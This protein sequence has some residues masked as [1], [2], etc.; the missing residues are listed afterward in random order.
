[1][2]KLFSIRKGILDDDHYF[3][4]DGW[5][6]RTYDKIKSSLNIEEFVSS[7]SIDLYNRQTML[8]SYPKDKHKT[9]NNIEVVI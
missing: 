8:A 5:I 3:F 4:E 9:I 7:D 2:E 6:H 1:M